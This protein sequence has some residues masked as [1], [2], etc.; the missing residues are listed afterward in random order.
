MINDYSTHSP[1]KDTPIVG[2]K[3]LDVWTPRTIPSFDDDVVVEL[4]TQYH[5]RPDL[6]ANDAYG[7]S[8]LWWVFS[9]RNPSILKDPIYDL[10]SGV[11]IYIPQKKQLLDSLGITA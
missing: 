8:R 3:Y 11:K 4:P 10:V 2:G 7:D 1:Y 5:H 9:V 6:L